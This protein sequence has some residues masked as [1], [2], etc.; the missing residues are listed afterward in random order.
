[1]AATNLAVSRVF[2][3]HH[4]STEVVHEEAIGKRDTNRYQ[5]TSEVPR[6]H[7]QDSVS[8]RTL[9]NP[10]SPKVSATSTLIDDTSYSATLPKQPSLPLSVE[11][12]LTLT[13]PTIE[14]L[15]QD[16]GSVGASMG[17]L[18]HGKQHFLNLG[19][20]GLGVTAV[21][22]QK[23]VYLISSMTKPIIA[24]A[25]G[26]LM[27]DFPRY[28]LD[29]GTRVSAVL[30][31][32]KG[33]PGMLKTYTKQELTIGDLLD[34]R[35]SF[36]WMTN[37]WESPDGDVPWRTTDPVVS[38]LQH[39]PVN[40][41]YTSHEAFVYN[42]NYSNECFALL[43]A[44]IERKTGYSWAKFVR[45]MVLEP[46]AMHNTFA[47]LS[48]AERN[49]MSRTFAKSHSVQV[50]GIMPELLQ[51]TDADGVICRAKITKCFERHHGHIPQSVEILPSQASNAGAVGPSPL[52]AAAG[53]MSTTSDLLK[54]YRKI[55]DVYAE[56]QRQQGS[57]LFP[58]PGHI[59]TPLERGMN[60]LFAHI[61]S[62]LSPDPFSRTCTYTGGWNTVTVPLT[63]EERNA[64]PRP[65]WP[66]ADG[67]NA[68]RL[69]SA[70]QSKVHGDDL[71]YTFFV[72]KPE[73]HVAEINTETEKPPITD[74]SESKKHLALYHGG[75][76]VGA[77]SFCWLLPD[78]ETA[79]VVLCNTRGF[80]LDAA[81]LSG[82]L[83]AECL[84]LAES[85]SR[86][87][88]G[89]LVEAV[90][91]ACEH[92]ERMARAIQIDYLY[93]LARYEHHLASRFRELDPASNGIDTEGLEGRYEFAQDVFITIT[94]EKRGLVLRLYG[95]GYGY[96]LRELDDKKAPENGGLEKTMTFAQPMAEL[97]PSGVG[98]TNRLKV[99]DF[100]VVFKREKA[101][102]EWEGFEWNFARGKT[103][104][105]RRRDTTPYFW[106]RAREK[107]T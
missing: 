18:R 21:P 64:S 76:M 92:T 57:K 59:S 100:V 8:I 69:E 55:M 13:K 66:G 32:L 102:G 86:H 2:G 88:T 84:F 24:T 97:I 79:V 39:L 99:K 61:E 47:G 3:F 54:F 12:I 28:Q 107:G 9:D 19:A 1:M 78:H 41:T 35:S 30:P 95:T 60:H 7:R 74:P 87:D 91:M 25:V 38:L 45:Q 73:P 16:S 101:A 65:R 77:T 71:D 31:E 42:R 105:E 68:R 67:D 29:F 22:D 104:R 81:N 40:D 103:P 82:M 50:P 43:A 37:L 62:R 15:L 34:L 98:G 96:L 48:E 93:D 11:E 20:R 53:I 89:S 36:Q 51:C 58:F 4:E 44:I 6:R 63:S 56:R 85:D 75:N 5:P 72:T 52:A 26:I 106:R 70:I 80:L 90:R 33:S 10:Y 27:D 46:L 83:L 94:A 23:T 49:D 17:V 14:R